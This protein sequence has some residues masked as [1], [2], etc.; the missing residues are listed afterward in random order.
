[1][2]RILGTALLVILIITAQ[3]TQ[4]SVMARSRNKP[5]S[6]RVMDEAESQKLVRRLEEIKTMDLEHMTRSEK[7]ALRKEVR[8]AHATM[9]S[10]GGGVYL[11]VGA[12]IIIILLLILLV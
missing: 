7:K 3:S 9:R 1:M 2:K 12:V 11:S 4:S 8:A 5:V 6:V 10:G